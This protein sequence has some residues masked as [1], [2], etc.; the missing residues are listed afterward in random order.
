MQVLPLVVRVV[1]DTQS[2]AF[3]MGEDERDWN[4]VLGWVN[5]PIIAQRKGPVQRWDLNGAPDI[6]DLEALLEKLRG[7]IGG[8]MPMYTVDGGFGRLVNVHLAYRLA[9]ALVAPIFTDFA[10]TNS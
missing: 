3:A 8:K 6:D 2:L 4:E 10:T 7:F 9:A 1:L 5:T